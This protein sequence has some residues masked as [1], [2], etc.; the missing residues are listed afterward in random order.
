MADLYTAA[1][2]AKEGTK[3]PDGL[4]IPDGVHPNDRG[5]ALIAEA[6]EAML[7][8]TIEQPQ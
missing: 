2:R 3:L 1:N 4:P 8:L 5:H 7:V 6:V